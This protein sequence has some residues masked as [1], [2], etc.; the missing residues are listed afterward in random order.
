VS[1]P[2]DTAWVRVSDP[3]VPFSFEVP[4]TWGNAAAYPWN[5]GDTTVGALLAAG[6]DPTKI[7]TDFSVPGIVIGLSANPG[8]AA[9]MALVEADDYSGVC[10]ATP[11][12]DASDATVTAAFRTWERCGADGAGFLLVIGL[13]P[14]DSAALVAVVLQG[15]RAEDAGYLEHILGSLA[16]EGGDPAATPVPAG[17][18]PFSISLDLCQNQHGAGVADGVIRNEDSRPHVFLIEIWFTDPAGVLL[19][20]GSWTTAGLAPG[21]AQQYDVQVT[22]IGGGDLVCRVNDVHVLS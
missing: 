17:D 2:S 9:P 4:T 5:E 13:V 14:V 18:E 19:S 15:S 1:P 16:V 3:A 10:T 22:G 6:P 8:G 20:T 21:Q 12:E 7:G 11:A